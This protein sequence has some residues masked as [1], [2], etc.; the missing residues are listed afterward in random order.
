MLVLL[1]ILG[2]VL[3]VRSRSRRRALEAWSQEVEP[4]L[5]QAT[6]VRGRL[7]G[8][9]Q[10]NPAERYATSEQL[11]SVTVS[12]TR[13]AGSAPSDEATTAANVVAENLRGLSFAQEAAS[14]LRTG[15]VP[16]TADQLAQADHTSRTQL[17][18]LD[19][20]IA[21]LRAAVS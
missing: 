6:I 13:I 5:A 12:L 20:A 7:V 3:L 15:P 11:Q 16:P 21:S 17:S 14:L 4:V 8:A 19:A 1:I 10:E 18:Q 9:Q 2:I